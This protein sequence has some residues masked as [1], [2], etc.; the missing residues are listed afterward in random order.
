MFTIC[1]STYLCRLSML[2]SH[3]LLEDD[4]LL[5]KLRQ[6]R[7][8]RIIEK[9][10]LETSFFNEAHVRLIP[11]FFKWW[12]PCGRLLFIYFDVSIQHAR[13]GR[14]TSMVLQAASCGYLKFSS[15]PS[16]YTNV[17]TLDCFGL[18]YVPW[19]DSPLFTTIHEATHCI[20]LQ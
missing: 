20:R 4:V 12:C 5:S 14:L 15:G 3:S 11:F 2:E 13:N 10:T 17:Q 6:C 19:S 1:L 7:F 18:M 16:S 8:V 9:E